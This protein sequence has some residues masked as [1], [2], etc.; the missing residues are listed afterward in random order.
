MFHNWSMLGERIAAASNGRLLLTLQPGGSIVPP[1]QELYGINDGAMDFGII[2]AVHYLNVV[3]TGGLLSGYL[4]G[5][6]LD[7]FSLR[8][9]YTNGGGGEFIDRA[10]ADLVP[11]VTHFGQYS[12]V[13]GPEIWAH[14][15]KELKSMSDFKGLKIR[16]LG[17]AGTVF[18]TMG[19]SAVAMPP[20]E[21]YESLQRGVIDAAENSGPAENLAYGYHNVAEYIYMSASRGPVDAQFFSVSTEVWNKL[22]Q[23]LK[24][25]FIDELQANRDYAVDHTIY[26]DIQALEQMEAEGAV[27][28]KLPSDIEREIAKFGDEFLAEKRAADP[29]YDEILSSMEAWR[30]TYENYFEFVKPNL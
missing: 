22:P 20:G 17:D 28:K 30:D 27:V 24:E 19:A 7:P 29:F 4:V 21:I 18:N 11:N 26:A 6:G 12:A 3:S 23:D 25:L 8:M 2:G 14:S 10:Y 16:T 13:I 15:T 5:R 1:A 9:W